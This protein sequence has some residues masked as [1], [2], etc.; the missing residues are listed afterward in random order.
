MR[1]RVASPPAARLYPSSVNRLISHNLCNSNRMRLACALSKRQAVIGMRLPLGATGR[2]GRVRIAW[3]EWSKPWRDVSLNPESFSW[4]CW[5]FSWSLV[6]ALGWLYN[7]NQLA[8]NTHWGGLDV[9]LGGFARLFE[10]RSWMLGVGCSVFTI[11]NVNT[12]PLSRRPRGGLGEPWYQHG[13]FLY[14]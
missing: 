6:G 1:P 14:P 12:T 13:T 11:R 5:R 3:S 2:H 10:A 7:R 4:L 9:A 8:F